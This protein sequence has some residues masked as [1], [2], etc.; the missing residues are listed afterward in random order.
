MVKLTKFSSFKNSRRFIKID[1]P[2]FE[3]LEGI[4]KFKIIEKVTVLQDINSSY[5]VFL[6]TIA[7]LGFRTL[8]EAVRA[9]CPLNFSLWLKPKC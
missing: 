4:Y 9:E 5:S 1:T 3:N 7:P 2:F 6:R 8:A